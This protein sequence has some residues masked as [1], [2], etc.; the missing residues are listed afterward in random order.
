MTAATPYVDFP[1]L[2]TMPIITVLESHPQH[3]PTSACIET[4]RT[5]MPAHNEAPDVVWVFLRSEDAN[6]ETAYKV[7]FEEYKK[8]IQAGQALI[9]SVDGR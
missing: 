2:R 3:T 1:S 4:Y 8:M 6:Q 7:S 9:A 5:R